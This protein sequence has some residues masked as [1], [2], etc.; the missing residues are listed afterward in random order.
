ML[1]IK[2]PYRIGSN[3]K[4]FAA[5]ANIYQQ[6]KPCQFETIQ[7][8]FQNT[9]W[10]D[11]N[12]LAMLGAIMES[13]WKN[14]FD[15]VNLRPEQEKIFKK[16]RYSYFG[17][18]SLPD[19]YQTTVEYRKTKVSEIGSFEKYLEKKLLAHPE[20]PS[21]SALLRK[22]I[23]ESILEIFDNA[24]T[25]GKCEFVFSC[26]QYYPRKGRLD[27]TVVDIGRTIRKN[28]RDYLHKNFSGKMALDWAV[29][30]NTTTRKDNIPGGLGFALI[31]EFLCKNNGKMQIASADGYWYERGRTSHSKDLNVFFRGTAVNLEFN[32]NDKSSYCLI[33]EIEDTDIPF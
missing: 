29:Q 32:V 28:V 24:R 18:E 8:D 2:L 9:T 23:K 15:I 31:R 26:G 25:H 10:F 4:G 14:D 33:S 17:G 6:V 19:H 11:A 3:Q 22:K 1:T 16:T 7:L 27:F 12:M 5:L 30:K 21:M 13:A 20:I